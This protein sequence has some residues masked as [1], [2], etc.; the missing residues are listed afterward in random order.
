MHFD[1]SSSKHKHFN[2]ICV[3]SV[4]PDFSSIN[5]FYIHKVH[6]ML[7]EFNIPI[8]SLPIS[9]WVILSKTDCPNTEREIKSNLH[10]EAYQ[11]VYLI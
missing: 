9:T 6:N 11:D 4:K 8:T 10:T 1:W 7:E 5:F 3:F 2:S